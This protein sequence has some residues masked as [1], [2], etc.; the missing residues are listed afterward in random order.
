M[1]ENGYATA[2]QLL[3][4]KP[5]PRRYADVVLPVSGHRLRIQSLTARELTG[6]EQAA[7]STGRN[8][9][10]IPAR[11]KDASARLIV[12]CVVDAQSNRMLSNKNIDEI[13]EWDSADVSALYSACAKHCGHD[14]AGMA[15]LSEKNS[16]G[17][18]SDA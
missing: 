10:F 1:S 14:T 11:I 3:T 5:A 18:L 9:S 8:L 7:V 6:Y 17:V 4:G 13:G 16:A 15:E 12:L 2:D